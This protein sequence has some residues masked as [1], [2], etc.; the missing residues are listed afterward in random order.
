[1]KKSELIN[2]IKEEVSM[3]QAQDDTIS[4]LKSYNGQEVPDDKIH[5]IADKHKISPHDLESFIY[6]LASKYVNSI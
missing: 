5:A 2:I 3:Q 4:L 6:S 1:M